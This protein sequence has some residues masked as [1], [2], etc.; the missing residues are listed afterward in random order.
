MKNLLEIMLNGAYDNFKRIFFAS[1]RVTDIEMRNAILNGEVKPEEKVNEDAC[2]G[3]GGCANV[4][5]TGA[6]SMKTLQSSVRLSNDWVKTEVP[7]ID[8]VKCVVCYWCHDFCPIYSLYGEAGTIHPNNV[9]DNEINSDELIS[10]PVKISSDKMAFIAQY[11]SDKS[12]LSKKNIV[13]G[14]KKS[15]DSSKEDSSK[16]DFSKEDICN[17][18]SI[19]DENKN[20]D[21]QDASQVKEELN[22]S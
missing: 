9:G 20:I 11:I 8:P 3:C 5:P 15:E 4:C 2:I 14:D 18:E 13:I 7:E 22:E 6:I 1:D 12:V 17:D 16:E 19:N 21:F 10:K